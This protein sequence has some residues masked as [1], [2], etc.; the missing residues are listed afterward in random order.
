MVVLYRQSVE[1]EQNPVI[2]LIGCSPSA[3]KLVEVHLQFRDKIRHI[4]SLILD[5]RQLTSA[6][7]DSLLVLPLVPLLEHIPHSHWNALGWIHLSVV[8]IEHLS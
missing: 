5:L 1:Q 2:V 8:G 4:L 6:E 3:E 7:P